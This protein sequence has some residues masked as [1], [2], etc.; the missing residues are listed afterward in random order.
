MKAGSITGGAPP[1]HLTL[2]S[3]SERI[4]GREDELGVHLL[5]RSKTGVTLTE[6]GFLPAHHA[7][8]IQHHIEQMCSALRQYDKGLRG[9]IPLL[10]NSSALSEYLPA[11]LGE[12]FQAHSTLSITVN[13]KRSRNIVNAIKNQM[14]DIGIVADSVDLHGL[15]TRPCR[16]DEWVVVIPAASHWAK[17]HVS[18]LKPSPALN[19]SA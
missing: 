17:N 3:A 18:F 9:H 14:A 11:L 16:Q 5:L 2:Q 8:V 1:S 6:V 7:N 4:R 15:E 19:L 10:C 12:Y 13:E